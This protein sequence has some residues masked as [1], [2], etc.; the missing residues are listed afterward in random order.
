[1]DEWKSL[2]KEE[3]KDHTLLPIVQAAVDIMATE[4]ELSSEDNRPPQ[5]TGRGCCGRVG[6]MR[7]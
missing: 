1:M 4:V 5:P 7:I 2:D 6:V 3:E